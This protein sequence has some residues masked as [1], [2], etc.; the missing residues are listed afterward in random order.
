MI[1]VDAFQ[2]GSISGRQCAARD[3]GGSIA[4]FGKRGGKGG[5][6]SD[7]KERGVAKG[8]LPQKDCVVCGRPFTWRKKWERSW[9]EV[10]CCSKKCNAERRSGEGGEN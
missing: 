9:D 1:S 7:K 4:L 8:N 2:A 5:K 10:T 3:F 6:G